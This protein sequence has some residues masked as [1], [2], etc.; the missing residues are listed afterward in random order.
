MKVKV[1][2]S[3]PILCDPMDYTVHGVLQARILEWVTIPSSRG[4]PNPG[5]KPRSPT[6]QAYSL[7]AEPPGKSSS[8]DKSFGLPLWLSW[9]RAQRKV[10]YICFNFRLSVPIPTK[11]KKTSFVGVALNLQKMTILITV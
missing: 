10:L 1:A 9:S 11:K 3:C 8:K 2:Q 5:I 6:L 7:L 4:F